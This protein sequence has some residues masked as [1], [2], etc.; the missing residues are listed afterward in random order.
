MADVLYYTVI[1]FPFLSSHLHFCAFCF[2]INKDKVSL[3]SDEII[4]TILKYNLKI[5]LLF[6]IWGI[7]KEKKTLDIPTKY[8]KPASE[9]YDH[10]IINYLKVHHL[11]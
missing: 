3:K 9:K 11:S 2:L 6:L 7:W 1:D 5:A 8:Q 4:C 10:E